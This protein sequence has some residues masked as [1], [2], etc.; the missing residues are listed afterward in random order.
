VSKARQPR[1]GS[2][3]EECVPA[4]WY[5]TSHQRHHLGVSTKQHAQGGNGRCWCRCVI[6]NL[7]VVSTS[8]YVYVQD[9]MIP[10]QRIPMDEF[11]GYVLMVPW[12]APTSTATTGDGG[13]GLKKGHRP[14]SQSHQSMR[15]NQGLPSESVY[16]RNSSS[17]AT[18]TRLRRRTR[19]QGLEQY[20]GGLR[21][22]HALLGAAG[23]QRAACA[24]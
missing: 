14:Q 16:E 9:N 1:A 23:S 17:R 6:C 22:P 10:P 13:Q 2:Q 21:E 8:V 7:A 19:Y 11:V 5:A 15:A 20:Q 3:S 12:F 24:L 18:A 4:H